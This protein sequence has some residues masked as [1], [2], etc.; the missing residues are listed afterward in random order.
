MLGKEKATCEDEWIN[1]IY[2]IYEKLRGKFFN[3]IDAASKYEL[4]EKRQLQF[5]SLSVKMPTFEGNLRSYAKFKSQVEC[6]DAL[7]YIL[8][9]CLSGTALELVENIDDIKKMW[10]YLDRKFGQPSMFVDIVMNE[11]R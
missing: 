8:K 3:H 5:R 7:A 6:L 11:V 2:D 10:E 9:S 4:K 1:E